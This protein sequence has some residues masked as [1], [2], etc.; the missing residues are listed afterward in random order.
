MHAAAHPAPSPNSSPDAIIDATV[1]RLSSQ[2][3]AHG[4]LELYFIR[5][6]AG[7][8]ITIESL[9]RAILTLSS[10]A[11]PNDV[12]IDRLSRSKARE[13]RQMA[14]AIKEL[15]A[16]QD[17]RNIVERFPDQTKDCPPLADHARFVGG[18]PSIAP[19]ASFLRGRMRSPL[20]HT[21]LRTNAP[22]PAKAAQGLP[23]IRRIIP[24]DQ[25]TAR[26]TTQ[27]KS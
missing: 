6:I 18:K 21:P 7:A 19:V 22:D 8:Q 16:L 14:V 5:Q 17:R 13:Q 1:Q 23:D 9:Q 4:E 2:Y 27:A 25:A 24:A 15:K 3:K 26:T 20:D 11:D 12:R 10:A